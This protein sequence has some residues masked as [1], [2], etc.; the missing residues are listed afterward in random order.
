VLLA[1]GITPSEARSSIRL[2][3]GYT[4]T[5]GEIDHAL[6]VMPKVVERLRA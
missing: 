4:T 1:M 6:G 2:S 5:D 3:L